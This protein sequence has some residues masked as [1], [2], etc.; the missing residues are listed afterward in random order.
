MK[1]T[2]WLKTMFVR[3]SPWDST[4]QLFQNKNVH[5]VLDYAHACARTSGIFF[6]MANS[7]QPPAWL[8][9]ADG[10]DQC[11]KNQV[12]I[13][14]FDAHK[15]P[16]APRYF[17]EFLSYYSEEPKKLQTGIT[18]ADWP[19][20]NLEERTHHD[21]LNIVSFLKEHL[22]ENRSEVRQQ[23][24][25]KHQEL[26]LASLNHL[27][28]LAIRMWLMINVL[29]SDVELV[30]DEAPRRP[31]S[32]TRS[33]EE[34]VKSLFQKSKTKLDMKESRLHPSFTASN[35]VKVCGLKVEWTQCLANHLRLDRRKKVLWV[36]SCKSF[37]QGQID[38]DEDDA[39]R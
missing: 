34:L 1:V 17:E 39:L 26:D 13:T 23:F 8:L 21:I 19:V 35:L 32:G 11:T 18:K 12:L 20:P 30:D 3:W 15:H 25:F 27:T 14:L 37:L 24:L 29:D 38:H 16:K 6:S 36:F 2:F 4:K 9:Q 22:T 31:W 7:N 28:D 5:K 10:M 33:L